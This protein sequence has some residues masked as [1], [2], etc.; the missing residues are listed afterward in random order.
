MRTEQMP[1]SLLRLAAATCLGLATC[2]A[3]NASTYAAIRN[4]VQVGLGLTPSY[5]RACLGCPGG[6]IVGGIVRLAFHDAVGAA[7]PN[8]RFGPNGC[9][10]LTTSANDNLADI[11]ALLDAIQAKSKFGAML[12]RADFWVLAATL[13]LELT[14][15]LAADYEPDLFNPAAT[16]NPMD[17]NTTPL[18]VPFLTGRVDQATCPGD[19]DYLPGANFN[20]GQIQGVFTTRVGM[21]PS[22]VIAI[23]GAH[24]LGE[25]GRGVNGNITGNWVQSGGC[26]AALRGVL[27]T[28]ATP[29]PPPAYSDELL[30]QLLLGTLPS[31]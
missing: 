28:A 25:I 16:P 18:V 20:W 17:K 12:S 2:A 13:V 22:E 7:G 1:A 4:D 5:G 23:L 24:S 14:S 19:A 30:E 9:L 6:H 31:P 21:T 15:T 29:R 10:D 11:I 26:H 3:I 27:S 8:R